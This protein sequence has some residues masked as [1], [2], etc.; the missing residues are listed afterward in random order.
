MYK[1]IGATRTRTYRVLWTL[2]E[3]GQEYEQIAVP[4]ASDAAREHNPS[5]KIP[6]LITDGAV[7]TDSVAI[8][9]FLAD[10]HGG[11]TY[12][13]GTV[14]RARMDAWLH[15]LNEEFDALLWM[16]ARH[17]RLLPEE[18]RVPE[19]VESLKWEFSRS[20]ER[21]AADLSG[22]F[23]MGETMTI[24]DILACHCINWALGAGFPVDVPEVRAYAKALRDRPAFKALMEE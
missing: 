13:A 17:A 3:L 24:A 1:V 15:R 7:L 14:E 21:M 20:V 10:R 12:P 18:R 5:G 2:R 19:V 8:M 11:L 22:P 4:P 6:A 16:A 23:L 9:S